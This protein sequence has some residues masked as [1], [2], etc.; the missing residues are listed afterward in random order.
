MENSLSTVTTA[1]DVVEQVLKDFRDG[2]R[3]GRPA[4]LTQFFERIQQESPAVRES[5]QLLLVLHDQTLRWQMWK[6]QHETVAVT[7]ATTDPN[8]R[9]PLLEDYVLHCAM[10]GG[11]TS[12]PVE[13]ISHEFRLR[14]ECGDSPTI[15][16]YRRRFPHLA[17]SLAMLLRPQPN[18]SE[19]QVTTQIEDAPTVLDPTRQEPQRTSNTNFGQYELLDEIA[20]GAM[21]VVYRARHTT[22]DK[23]VALKMILAG[24][25]ATQHQI[26]QFLSEAKNAGQLEHDHIVRIYDAG[27]I[28]DQYFIAMAYIE[29]HSLADLVR[30]TS[31]G[32]IR[33]A[34]IV[35]AVARALHFAHLQSQ[36]LYH[37]DI[38]PA[39]I[40]MD[41][42]GRP[43]ITD[44]G[45]A[46]RVERDASQTGK[47]DIAGTPSYMPP[48]QTY[49]QNI[50]PWSD[51]YSTGALLYHLLTGRPPFLGESPVE[52]IRQVR[53]SEPLAPS[54]L[55]PKV[56]P[57]LEAVCL[58][59]LK[60]EFSKRYRSAEALADDLRRFLDHIPTQARPLSVLGRFNKWCRR[61][62]A[63]AT[64]TMLIAALLIVVSI[65]SVKLFLDQR[66]LT[67]SEIENRAKADKVAEQ[68]TKLA[69][70]K[71]ELAEQRKS[72]IDAE[73]QKRDAA[74]KL[75]S[76]Q[77]E[78]AEKQRTL[79]D[80]EKRR[81]DAEAKKADAE[82]KRADD[83]KRNAD[84]QEKLRIKADLATQLAEVNL[85]RAIQ[86]IN[87][88]LT[89][90]A[91][92]ELKNVPGM[93]EFRKRVAQ[94]ALEQLRPIL[95]ANA[96]HEAAIEA[97][98]KVRVV[99]AK[100]LDITG[101][102]DKAEGVYVQAIADYER[103][104]K[105]QPK[106]QTYLLDMIVAYRQWGD[107]LTDRSQVDRSLANDLLRRAIEK[108]DLAMKHAEALE[109]QSDFAALQEVARTLQSQ[110]ISYFYLNDAAKDGRHSSEAIAA[111]RRA[112]TLLEQLP[113]QAKPTDDREIKRQL[114][115]V[116]R[117]LTTEEFYLIAQP[118]QPQLELWLEMVNRAKEM[119]APLVAGDPEDVDLRYDH[120][121]TCW[122]RARLLAVLATV[123]PSTS[124]SRLSEEALREISMA[125][126][127]F[128]RL[129]EDFQR[130]PSYEYRRIQALRLQA[131]ILSDQGELEKSNSELQ[132]ADQA[133]QAYQRNPHFQKSPREQLRY[134]IAVAA[135]DLCSMCLKK[136]DRITAKAIAGWL[137]D[138]LQE[139]QKSHDPKVAADAKELSR[140]IE[141][142]LN[143][144]KAPVETGK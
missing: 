114:A 138:S 139:L 118:D 42:S 81:A 10:D 22:I 60:K 112:R 75:A 55:N 113:T 111:L 67:A 121:Q 80:S 92:S 117:D 83:E 129:A 76:Q 45:I 59:C 49:G 50:G 120:A 64:L 90:S 82:K 62:T 5:V 128:G 144:L 12:L 77:S 116:L 65:G 40:L 33:A 85:Q 4:P 71:S 132:A 124:K 28:N 136:E 11:L 143:F 23:I 93:E 34:E 56:D 43:Y 32:A 126:D 51:V 18:F 104:R 97:M 7:G 38:K 35:E 61:N 47:N 57:D 130:T 2:W 44:F 100:L 131:I 48:E 36:P 79:A 89:R 41:Q 103:L 53:E 122:C 14:V 78:L 84:E 74:D 24:Q 70:Q 27:R 91:K 109:T 3:L 133:I 96:K 98:A 125:K 16:D 26:D 106:N 29:G 21:G 115:N 95:E 13:L 72:L 119:I 140:R 31:L 68:Q 88:I 127:G 102:H 52:T 137:G 87:L 17:A 1:V 25:F 73:T 105:D 135:D 94:D 20:R 63:V 66:E 86:A 134:E 108:H 142:V 123:V 6:R 101:E 141:R 54:E 107:S 8:V 30:E 9:A 58:K 46:K 19:S 15:E 110:S 69:K 39:N 37:R 99:Q